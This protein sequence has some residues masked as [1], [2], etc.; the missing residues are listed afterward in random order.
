[1]VP[2]DQTSSSPPIQLESSSPVSRLTGY[3][4]YVCPDL[5]DTTKS[6]STQSGSINT[7]SDAPHTPDVPVGLN[8]P[9]DTMDTTTSG[10]TEERMDIEQDL[11]V[12]R[13]E[14]IQW[15]LVAT[16]GASISHANCDGFGTWI[17]VKSQVKVWIVHQDNAGSESE[18]A[19]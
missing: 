13:E 2:A 8:M 9:L 6:N 3:E 19:L 17:D 5:D 14:G 15:G 1:V 11:P 4:T 10:A 18:P 12:S 7:R 16:A